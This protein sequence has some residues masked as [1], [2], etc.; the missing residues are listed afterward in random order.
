M[1][2]TLPSNKILV[3]KSN[4]N[5]DK[6]NR[7]SE[8][9]PSCK[10][11]NTIIT[12]H[13]TGE[14]ICSKCGMVLSDKLSNMRSDGRPIVMDETEGKASTGLPSLAI[15]DMGLSTVIG[16]ENTDAHRNKIEP[17][18]LSTMH[19][20]RTWDFRTQ[21]HDSSDKSLRFA[22]SE[23]DSLKDKLGLSDAIIERTAYIY[24]KAQERGMLRGRS[25]LGVLAAAIHIACRQL[26]VP[27]TLDDI[28]TSS[29]VKRK[30]IAKS[31]RD[32]IF[33]LHLNLP[34]I[35]TTK[36]IVGVANKANISE[37][38]K[39]QA[40]NLMTDAV[41][42]GIAAGK[43][44]MGLAATVLYASCMKTGERKTQFELAKAAQITDATIRNRFKDLKSQLG[45]HY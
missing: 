29:N 16:K 4:D 15:H 37:K 9:C 36:C 35:D 42:N 11:D 28:A 44:P 8:V 14:I 22:F 13:K 21:V 19:R 34:T 32:L 38:T 2:K 27:R 20:L 18:M 41:K 31:H 7:S 26:N 12:D 39:H 43:D 30:S 17:S 45:L 23:L 5:M 10:R 1:V 33:Q 3:T 25:I 6:I 40:I 24:R